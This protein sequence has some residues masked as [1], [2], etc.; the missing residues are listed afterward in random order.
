M[1]FLFALCMRC[2]DRA[3]A[4]I[5]GADD[6]NAYTQWSM[7]RDKLA[8]NRRTLVEAYKAVGKHDSKWDAQAVQLLEG[9]A[10]HLSESHLAPGFRTPKPSKSD[11]AVVAQG[12]VDAGCDDP[13][14][15]DMAAIVFDDLGQ[16]VKA[17][18]LVRRAF[19]Q[20]AAGESKYPVA[21][22]MNN[23]R[24]ARKLTRAKDEPELRAKFDDKLFELSIRA[25]TSGESKGFD[26]RVLFEAMDD[27]A[28][29]AWPLDRSRK[30]V[31][32]IAA[33]KNSDPWLV[34]MF[35]GHHFVRAA[36]DARGKGFADTVTPEGW[37][38]FSEALAKARDNLA[39]AWKLEPKYPE[40]ASLMITVAMGGAAAPNENERVWFDRAV[41]GQLDFGDAYDNFGYSLLP[42]WNGSY[43]QI[44]NFGVE[45]AASKRFDTNVPFQLIKSLNRIR[46]DGAGWEIWRTDGV[47]AAAR[48]VLIG[49]ANFKMPDGRNLKNWN[50]SALAG[51]AWQVQRYDVAREALNAVGENWERAGLESALI[52]TP[53]RVISGIYA[54]SGE[55]A[56]E[57]LSAEELAR[58]NRY[59]E[60]ADAYDKVAAGVPANDPTLRWIKSRAVEHRQ[61]GTFKRGEAVELRPSD[62]SLAGFE[63]MGGKWTVENGASGRALLGTADARGL[64]MVCA[65]R[66]GP[67][68]EIRATIEFVDLGGSKEPGAGML[69]AYYSSSRYCS[70]WIYPTS[71]SARMRYDPDNAP[72]G[73]DANML[74]DGA[75]RI[76]I[77][78]W[79]NHGEFFLNDKGPF[80]FKWMRD[81]SQSPDVLVGFSTANRA[82]RV[83]V[84]YTDVTIRPLDKEP[85]KH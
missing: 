3:A 83:K 49:Y 2:D 52:T 21:R 1:I 20:F 66:F 7:Q 22:Q 14:V 48:D 27:D 61:L 46:D 63:T 13:L 55:H 73:W 29:S 38:G 35:T 51:Y 17:R 81:W 8:L 77:R 34:K 53:F 47:L 82:D 40:S 5:P 4:A 76:T 33:D 18:E 62:N 58:Q 65:T 69:F 15:L 9:S 75:N 71:H 12:V 41:A 43:E 37:R 64:S 72:A 45:C 67:R 24:R 11:L 31:D 39:E 84:R 68:Y 74:V 6:P 26:R 79:N 57:L 59:A 30:F 85:E 70:N 54:L 44:V 28:H 19:D 36:W 10:L 78:V 25:V 56:K 23:A 50:Y 42:R 60:A 80:P 32:A 16:D